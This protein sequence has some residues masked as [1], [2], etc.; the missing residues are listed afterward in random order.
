MHRRVSLLFLVVVLAI[1]CGSTGSSRP[2]NISAPELR[3]GIAGTVFFGSGTSAP[4]TIDVAV[5]NTATVP[6][7]LR[8]LEVDSPGMASYG[9]IRTARTMR[10]TLAPGETKTV[11]VFATAVTTVRNPNE[12]LNIRVIADFEN[13]KD[14]WREIKM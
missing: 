13:G 8:R 10:E 9:L 14:R 4:V 6:I 3:A 11:S 5:T 12:P 2:A 1:A 7:V